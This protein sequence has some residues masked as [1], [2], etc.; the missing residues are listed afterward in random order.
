MVF[1]SAGFIVK[2]EKPGLFNFNLFMKK[3]WCKTLEN[4][5]VTVGNFFLEIYRAVKDVEMVEDT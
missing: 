2:E 4:P 1:F 5:H 3:P